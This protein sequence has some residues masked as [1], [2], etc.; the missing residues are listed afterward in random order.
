MAKNSKEKNEGAHFF[1]ALAA[2]IY[3][4][5]SD[6]PVTRPKSCLK[7]E[8]S[9]SGKYCVNMNDFDITLLIEFCICR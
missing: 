5:P 2:Q 8:P 6:A 1:L 9:M 7:M 4:T 3:F